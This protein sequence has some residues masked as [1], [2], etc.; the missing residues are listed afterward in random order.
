M[1]T[2]IIPI[3]LELLNSAYDIFHTSTL[4]RVSL[5]LLLQ[6][7]DS[8]VYVP[9][10]SIYTLLILLTLHFHNSALSFYKNLLSRKQIILSKSFSLS[11][12]EIRI[13]TFIPCCDC[14]HENMAYMFTHLAINCFF[15]S[16]GIIRK[17]SLSFQLSPPPVL[18][19]LVH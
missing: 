5:I 19:S 8:F 11:P 12:G 1:N 16:A 6:I 4:V 2:C 10:I 9:H 7:S 14:K 3:K 17:I 15:S 13:C 18:I